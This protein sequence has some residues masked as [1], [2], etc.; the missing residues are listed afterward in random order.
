[1]VYI[2]Y[3]SSEAV[4]LGK[5]LSPRIPGPMDSFSR[6]PPCFHWWSRNDSPF[7]PD[8]FTMTALSTQMILQWQP[9]PPRWFRNDSPFHP[10]DLAMTALSTQM[11]SQWQPFPP[12]LMISQMTALSTQI[13]QVCRHINQRTWKTQLGHEPQGGA[14][15]ISPVVADNKGVIQ[16]SVTVTMFQSIKRKQSTQTGQAKR[17]K[18]LTS[19]QTQTS[20]KPPGSKLQSCKKKPSGQPWQHAWCQPCNSG[21]LWL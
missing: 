14:D 3:T 13:V 20:C 12:S 4:L 5:P 6:S 11:I 2:F 8:Y 15:K 16:S 17:F 1:M 21:L 9:F 7:H 19:T 10:D 18:S